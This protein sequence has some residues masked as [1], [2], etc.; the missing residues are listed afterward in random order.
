MAEQTKVTYEISRGCVL[1]MGCIYECPVQAISMGD[2]TMNIN[3]E[4]CTGCGIC[5]N[6]CAFEAIR[7]IEHKN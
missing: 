2:G 7:K 4:K 6:N 3:A 1:C 5:W